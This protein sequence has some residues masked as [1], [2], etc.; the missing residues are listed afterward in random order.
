VL[1]GIPAKQLR[2]MNTH[3]GPIWRKGV[4]LK[5]R[6]SAKATAC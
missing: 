4:Y 2:Q 5:L 1:A 6:V 3:R